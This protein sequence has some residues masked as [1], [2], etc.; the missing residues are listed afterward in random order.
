MSNAV[1]NP[2]APTNEPVKSYAPGSP[3]RTAL[4]AEYDRRIKATIDAP[5]WIGGKEIVTKDKRKMSPPHKHGHSLGM[6]HF[7][8]AKTVKS[9]IDAALKD[10]LRTHTLSA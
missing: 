7:G 8:D 5:M 10:W 4:Q 1:F 9:A 3:E 2:P 6:A